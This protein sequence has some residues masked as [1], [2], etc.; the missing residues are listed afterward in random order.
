M[1]VS[2]IFINKKEF[3]EVKIERYHQTIGVITKCKSH[4]IVLQ[5]IIRP[6]VEKVAGEESLLISEKYFPWIRVDLIHRSRR[7]H[8]P[9]LSS[10]FDPH[11]ITLR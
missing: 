7:L 2:L 6:N 3:F 4:C 10:T 11:P 8:V 9:K 1:M 5:K